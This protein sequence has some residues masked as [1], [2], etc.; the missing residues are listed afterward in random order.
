MTG[1]GALH[2]SF[3]PGEI[4][5]QPTVIRRVLEVVDP[6]SDFV[7]RDLVGREIREVVMTG[8]GDSLF[9]AMSAAFSFV[10]FSGRLTVPLHA[11]EYSRAFYR[12][13]GPH[14]LVC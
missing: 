3:L 10:Q 11:L 1:D 6:L 7:A 9:S 12:T 5:L 2:D 4:R 8:C 13:S 14:T